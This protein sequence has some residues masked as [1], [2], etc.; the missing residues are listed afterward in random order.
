MMSSDQQRPQQTGGGD[1]ELDFP[2]NPFMSSVNN[3]NPP[4]LNESNDLL[5]QQQHSLSQPPPLTKSPM[6]QFEI[7]SPEETS[8]FQPVYVGSG[9]MDNN[10]N[11]PP[12]DPGNTQS[13]Y[14]SFVAAFQIETYKH[15][16]NMDT[17]DIQNRIV[18]SLKYANEPDYFM[19]QVLGLNRSDGKGPDLYGPVW[20]CMTMVF[21][22]AV[23]LVSCQ[24]SSIYNAMPFHF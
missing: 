16:F 5:G 17:I 18:G 24:L 19:E 23:S 4:D 11:K 7:D 6:D 10:A 3:L 1:D 14:Q 13:C 22:V 8:N 15:Y 12:N 20:I 21:L 2:V 9:S